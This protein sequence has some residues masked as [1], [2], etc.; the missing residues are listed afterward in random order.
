MYLIYHQQGLDWHGPSAE[1]AWASLDGLIS[2]LEQ[3]AIWEAWRLKKD[4]RVIVLGHSNGGQGAY[5]LASRF[6]D[7][8]L[9]GSFVI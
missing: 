9:G 3:G 7:R 2:I 1:D 6:P 5:Y 4:T 8:V